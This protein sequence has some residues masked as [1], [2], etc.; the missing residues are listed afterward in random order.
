[1]LNIKTQAAKQKMMNIADVAHM[2][3]KVDEAEGRLKSAEAGRVKKLN[4]RHETRQ[5]TITL[6]D[7]YSNKIKMNQK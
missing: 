4:T 5:Q 2:M 6:Y 7:E 1:M 3:K